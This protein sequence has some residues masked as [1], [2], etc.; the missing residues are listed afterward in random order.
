MNEIQYF[1]PH[2]SAV[3]DIAGGATKV[4]DDTPVYAPDGIVIQS[5]C[6]CG[7]THVIECDKKDITMKFK[8]RDDITKE[9]RN[10]AEI[11]IQINLEEAL[12]SLGYVQEDECSEENYGYVCDAIEEIKKA[13]NP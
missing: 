6:D 3:N 4:T 7:L 2:T 12:T 8:R 1:D 5:C 9:L 10:T 13:I 11:P